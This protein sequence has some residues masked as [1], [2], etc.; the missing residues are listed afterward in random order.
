M[1]MEYLT[2]PRTSAGLSLR[3]NFRKGLYAEISGEYT[4]GF[5]LE[6]LPGAD[7]WGTAAMIGCTF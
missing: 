6:F 5:R 1:H 7:R 2:A 3:F 4:R